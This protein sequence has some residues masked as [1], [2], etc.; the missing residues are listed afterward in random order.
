MD[1]VHE[2]IRNLNLRNHNLLA[3]RDN[4]RSTLSEASGLPGADVAW[5][6]KFPRISEAPSFVHHKPLI[7]GNAPSRKTFAHR[8]NQLP[9]E[10]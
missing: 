5:L 6:G 4:F 9:S 10:E 7:L 1:S 2:E 3:G 8:C